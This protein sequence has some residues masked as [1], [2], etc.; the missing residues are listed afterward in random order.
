MVLNLKG[1]AYKHPGGSFLIEHTVGRDISKFFYGGY[2]MD[3]NSRDPTASNPRNAHS[4]VARK[5]VNKHIVAMLSNDK[6]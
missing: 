2:A 3:G 6:V 5:I 1:F 4:N